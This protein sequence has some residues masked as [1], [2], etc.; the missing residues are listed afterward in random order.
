MPLR[1]SLR[2]T[3]PSAPFTESLPLTDD[4]HTDTSVSLPDLRRRVAPLEVLR[5]TL[6]SPFDRRHLQAPDSQ[7]AFSAPRKPALGPDRRLT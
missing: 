1:P 6:R 4:P 7:F 5:N 2:L 3:R